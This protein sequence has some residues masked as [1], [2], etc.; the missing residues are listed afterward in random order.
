MAV[1]IKDLL[2]SEIG[3]HIDDLDIPVLKGDK[4]DKGEKGDKPIVGV[5]YYTEIEKN[6]FKNAIVKDSKEDIQKHA[7]NKIEEYDNNATERIKE[8]NTNASNK[9]NEYD[10]NA[11]KLLN[12]LLGVETEIK[13]DIE[14]KVDKIE[15][16]ELSSNDFTDGYK[17]KLDNL[18]N[19][20]DTQIKKYISDIEEEQIIKDTEQDCKILEL[21][22]KKTEIEKELKEVQ[23]DF[24]QSSIRGQASGE[25][26]HVEDSSNCRAKIKISGNSEQ[27]KREGYNIMPSAKK[28]T[29]TQNGVI[30]TCDGY[31]IYSIKGTATSD[32]TVMFDL[33]KSFII[34][35]S[36]GNS[37]KGCMKI[38]NSI[39]TKDARIGFYNNNTKIDEWTLE[40]ANRIVTTYS[41]QENKECN[42][43]CLTVNSGAT[44]DMTL[45]P[46]FINDGTT[47]KLYEQYGVMP[48]PD[49]PSEIK[50]V[51]DNINLF[52]GSF[53]QGTHVSLTQANR[54]I[55][56]NVI[57]SVKGNNYTIST[58]LSSEYNYKIQNDNTNE[59]ENVNV[60]DD[61][62]YTSKSSLTIKCTQSGYLKILVNKND[63][64]SI[65]PAEMSK[66]YFKVEK[67]L[68]ATSYSL[69]GQ[70]CITEFICNENY[71]NVNFEQGAISANVGF[72]YGSVKTNSNSRIRTVDLIKLD[73]TKKYTIIFNKK[74]NVVIQAF[75]DNKQLYSVEDNTANVWHLDSFSFSGYP[76]I[77]IAVKNNDNTSIITT[78][79]TDNVNLILSDEIQTYTMPT[80]KEMLQGDYFDFDNEEEV[81]T[82]TKLVLNGTEPWGKSSNKYPTFWFSPYEIS[83]KFAVKNGANG[84]CNYFE[85][86]NSVW[87]KDTIAFDIANITTTHSN[88]RFCLGSNSTITTLEEWKSKLAEMYNSGQPLIVYIQLRTP[89]RL[90]F[91]DEQ[92]AIA[93]ELNN[94]RTYKNV[95]NITTDSKAIIDLDY[96]KDLETLLNNVQALALSN[97]SEEV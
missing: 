39:A 77:A 69:H 43:I 58:N 78:K 8:Y 13:K 87:E 16:K 32:S 88:V 80:Q 36:L 96:V 49:Y 65:T 73:K 1:E 35:K 4:G 10:E 5:D 2:S 18:E 9:I 84:L 37:G 30:Y 28:T 42:Q 63:G 64:S 48:S 59:I 51:G 67:G 54:I 27:E 68:V 92:K 60:I 15:G 66:Y 81:H 50:S 3:I 57:K 17:Q 83:T 24:Y 21:Q 62:S 46:I 97:A 91:T 25:Y 74:Y 76:Y 85:Q 70:G 56:Q 93:K 34:P 40:V 41:S 53:R 22:N 20:D 29:I 7:A 52:D 72:Y 71:S 45:S 55:S 61:T 6:E 19:Y 44:I 31:G 14:R 95:T 23:E 47:D 89:E 11:N 94:A 90:A 75:D 82:W 38:F 33:E 86:I 12:K 79:E 26:I